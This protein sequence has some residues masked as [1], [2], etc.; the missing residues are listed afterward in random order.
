MELY[1]DDA[2]ISYH[3]VLFKKLPVCIFGILYLLELNLDDRLFGAFKAV[4]LPTA[5]RYRSSKSF[6]DSNSMEQ[7]PSTHFGYL[8][9]LKMKFDGT[10]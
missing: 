6:I 7:T 1:D 5:T 3:Q 4:D 2:A 8:L 10:A 9:P